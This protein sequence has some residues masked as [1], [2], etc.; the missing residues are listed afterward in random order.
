MKELHKNLNLE[1]YLH[2]LDIHSQKICPYNMSEYIGFIVNIP[3]G[4]SY[5]TNIGFTE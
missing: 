2:L 4:F 5:H 1:M 3:E